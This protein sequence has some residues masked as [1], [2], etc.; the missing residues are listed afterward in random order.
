M[1]PFVHHRTGRGGGHLAVASRREGNTYGHPHPELLALLKRAGIPLLRTD[2]N[3]TITIQ[4]DGK[5][6][7][8]VCSGQGTRGPPKA[9][10]EA[11]KTK[12]FE[13]RIGSLYRTIDLHTA[14]QKELEGLPGIGPVIA[15]RIMEGRP[16]HPVEELRRV[17]GIGEK[18]LEGIRGMVGVR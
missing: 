2:L 1:C 9:T 5:N 10:T 15:R 18:K 6:W 11:G 16:Y 17:K 14:T 4:T 12:K 8:V 13:S 3:G 7:Q